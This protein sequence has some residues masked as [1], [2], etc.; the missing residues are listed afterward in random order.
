MQ[1]VLFNQ[2]STA[3]RCSI[4]HRKVICRAVGVESK[5]QSNPKGIHSDALQLATSSDVLAACKTSSKVQVDVLPV[6]F[7]FF[8]PKVSVAL[9]LL[10][11]LDKHCSKGCICFM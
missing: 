6:D 10:E 2:W 5:N 8:L 11:K 7:F 9:W 3:H 4:K 1:L